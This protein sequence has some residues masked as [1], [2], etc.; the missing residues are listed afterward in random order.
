M[1]TSAIRQL[2]EELTRVHGDSYLGG[3]VLRKLGDTDFDDGDY[4]A[5]LGRYEAAECHLESTRQFESRNHVL[6]RI[7]ECR[8]R[9]GMPPPSH[10]CRHE[11]VDP[12]P[13]GGKVHTVHGWV[14]RDY[15]RCRDC[16]KEF[17][18]DTGL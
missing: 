14:W 4:Q 1:T 12:E 11:H 3:R 16:G 18:Q 2:H 17:K 10:K 15:Y 8:S 13:G 7:A 5:A 9:L 6:A